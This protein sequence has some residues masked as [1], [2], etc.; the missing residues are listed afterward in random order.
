MTIEIDAS[1]LKQIEL[2]LLA[3]YFHLNYTKYL[4]GVGS[5]NTSPLG[6]VLI[7]SDVNNAQ[8]GPG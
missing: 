3:L 2:G 4:F 5:H 8:L 7:T 6:L 1:T